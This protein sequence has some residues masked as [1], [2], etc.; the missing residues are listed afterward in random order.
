MTENTPANGGNDH[1]EKTPMTER[2]NDSQ[3][4]P[5]AEG[6]D[7]STLLPMLIG[8]LALIM[9]GMVAIALIV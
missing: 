3:G 4:S 1:R 8:G 6:G 5:P 9:I 7:V 2:R